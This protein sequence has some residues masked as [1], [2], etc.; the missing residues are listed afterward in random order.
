MQQLNPPCGR[1]K[2]SQCSA[3]WKTSIW[4]G[5]HSECCCCQTILF[6]TQEANCDFK[7]PVRLPTD[8]LLFSFGSCWHFANQI[9][10]EEEVLWTFSCFHR[11]SPDCICGVTN[12]V[13]NINEWLKN[14]RQL[15]ERNSYCKKKKKGVYILQPWIDLEKSTKIVLM[16]V[17]TFGLHHQGAAQHPDVMHMLEKHWSW[18]IFAEWQHVAS[19]LI[20]CSV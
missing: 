10:S 11:G 20:Y 5:T 17:K 8:V 4:S 15:Y 2:T 14:R 13:I 12:L 19:L 6:P 9:K 3:L 7:I 18:F 1:V 16:G